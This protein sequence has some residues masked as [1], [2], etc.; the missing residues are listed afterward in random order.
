MLICCWWQTASKFSNI[1]CFSSVICFLFSSICR[2]SLFQDLGQFP[3]VSLLIFRRTT[4]SAN[5]TALPPQMSVNLIRSSTQFI[6]FFSMHT[7]I[8]DLFQCKSTPRSHITATEFTGKTELISAELRA[9]PRAQ[10]AVHAAY[11][12]L[13]RIY[14]SSSASKII[15]NVFQISS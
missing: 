11:L 8:W 13:M 15:L 1:Y 6:H 5:F 14:L 2:G 7:C 9:S 3:T 12:P 4:S 10:H